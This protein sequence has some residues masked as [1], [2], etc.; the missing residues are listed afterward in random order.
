M[1]AVQLHIATTVY[2][3]VL[4]FMAES[5]GESMERTQIPKLQTGSKL[6]LNPV[7]PDWQSGILLLSYGAAPIWNI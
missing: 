1:N 4:I 7:S 3:Q 6:D 2:S 5:T